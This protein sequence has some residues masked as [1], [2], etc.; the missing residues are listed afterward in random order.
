MKGYDDSTYG[1]S[2]AD[3]YDDWY[4]D[5]SDVNATVRTLQQL[6]GNGPFHELG[7]G[8]GRL[9]LALAQ[10]GATVSGID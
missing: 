10:T 1:N 9:A 7:I 6:G 4:E 5:V 3:V 2:F 8:T